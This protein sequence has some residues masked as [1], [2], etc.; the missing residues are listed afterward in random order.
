MHLLLIEDDHGDS[1]YIE[2]ILSEH[3]IDIRTSLPPENFS[4]VE[5]DFV[6]C[7]YF[8]SGRTILEYFDQ[9]TKIDKAMP[10]FILISGKL[11]QISIDK[12]PKRMNS[13]ILSKNTNFKEMLQYHVN[14]IQTIGGGV[15]EKIDYKLLFYELVHDLRND[16]ALSANFKDISPLLESV[17]EEMNFLRDV[18]NSSLYAYNRVSTLSDFV[19]SD[20]KATGTIKQALKSLCGS[21]LLENVI[22]KTKILKGEDVVITAL[23]LY[24]VSVVLKNL[25]ENSFKYA[26]DK[27]RLE[28]TIMVEKSKEGLNISIC[29]N[30]DGIPEDKINSLFQKKQDSSNGMGIGLVILNRIVEIYK[31]HINVDSKVGVGTKIQISFLNH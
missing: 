7:D 21:P 31:G 17:E 4:L 20:T 1:M 19:K 8:V 12:I 2:E 27:D 9:L 11:D 22:G 30:G 28:I 24:F 29:D 23:P 3:K 13:F 26:T 18:K 10:P 16:L 14:L 6:I 25:L 15:R 5:Y